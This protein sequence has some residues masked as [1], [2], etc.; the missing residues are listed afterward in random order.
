MPLIGCENNCRNS[1]AVESV[2]L[3]DPEPLLCVECGG[4]F[5]VVKWQE[6]PVKREQLDQEGR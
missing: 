3:C 5:Q 2:D 4:R 1:I 6:L